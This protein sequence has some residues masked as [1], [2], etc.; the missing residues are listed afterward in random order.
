VEIENKKKHALTNTHSADRVLRNTV[1]EPIGLGKLTPYI[2]RYTK[3]SHSNHNTK[4]Q[5]SAP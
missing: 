3:A 4:I 2:Y 1:I 5:I